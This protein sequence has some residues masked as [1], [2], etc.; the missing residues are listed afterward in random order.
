MRT[1]LLCWIFG[2][3]LIPALVAADESP[4][5]GVLGA[6]E[7]SY[8]RI[9]RTEGF[10]PFRGVIHAIIS[11][12]HVP[13]AKHR[14]RLV[15]HTGRLGNMALLRPEVHLDLLERVESLGGW[16]LG[17]A[18]DP[19][20]GASQS[21]WKVEVRRAGREHSFSFTRAGAGQDERYGA[22]VEAV[23]GLV[24]E[25]T[26]D[27]PFRNVFHDL[28]DRGYVDIDSRPPARVLFDGRATGYR[29]PLYTYE[30]PSGAHE[31]R[32]IASDEGLDRTYEFKV[33]PG[34]TTVLHLDLR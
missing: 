13:V 30:L 2:V 19:G 6:I 18:M 8:V 20:P 25:H 10:S 12:S 15:N 32:L 23:V 16:T 17:D 26:G 1:L 28:E 21:A 27:V 9:T 29:T 4:G 5:A 11:R 24:V 3:A 14:K 34:K 22:I 33:E 7:D 31:V